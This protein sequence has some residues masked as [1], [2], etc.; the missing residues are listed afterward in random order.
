MSSLKPKTEEKSG[1]W[2]AATTFRQSMVLDRRLEKIVRSGNTL[3]N[4]TKTG[5][6][7][8][9]LHDKTIIKFDDC[10]TVAGKRAERGTEKQK[11]GYRSGRL[12]YGDPPITPP[13]S[14]S[15]S[16]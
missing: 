16:R 1:S 11:K 15:D 5:Q 2:P 4:T 14:I 10:R 9:Q 7:A 12:Q 8:A 3:K 6:C 13:S